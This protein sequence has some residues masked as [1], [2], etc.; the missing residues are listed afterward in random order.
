MSKVKSLD[1]RPKI[2]SRQGERSI[3]QLTSSIG[4]AACRK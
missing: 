3:K 4:A 2:G 1:N